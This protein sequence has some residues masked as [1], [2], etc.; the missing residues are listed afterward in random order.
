M[1]PL[2]ITEFDTVKFEA[3]SIWEFRWQ[4][5]WESFIRLLFAA[6]LPLCRAS[7]RVP[8]FITVLFG[9]RLLLMAD[10]VVL[11]ACKGG[12]ATTAGPAVL[13]I[14]HLREGSPLRSGCGSSFHSPLLFMALGSSPCML[15]D[16]L[17]PSKWPTF[18]SMICCRCFLAFYSQAASFENVPLCILIT[19]LLC[20]QQFALLRFLRQ[21]ILGYSLVR[22][23]TTGV[24]KRQ[25]KTS[26]SP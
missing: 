22:T 19:P 9:P 23:E 13:L 18:R 25:R 12:K 20:L 16:T 14:R 6:L 8:G 24:G 17:T 11:Y 15:P 3:I 21:L 2:D 1:F 10:G 4:A 26:L 5:Q 7:S